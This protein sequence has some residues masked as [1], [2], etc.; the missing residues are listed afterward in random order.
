MS[1]SFQN[2]NKLAIDYVR[3][4]KTADCCFFSRPLDVMMRDL[5]HSGAAD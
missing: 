4:L 2:P 1:A 3:G 5:K